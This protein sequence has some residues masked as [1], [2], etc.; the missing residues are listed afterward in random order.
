MSLTYERIINA[1]KHI[2]LNLCNDSRLTNQLKNDKKY[3]KDQNDFSPLI[4]SS[5]KYKFHKKKI[6]SYKP[7]KTKSSKPL[8][9]KF[10]QISY[11][12]CKIKDK[13][14]KLNDKSQLLNILFE[15]DT[16]SE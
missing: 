8:H 4:A 16:K 15:S 13:I 6:K 11:Y 5:I 2:E 9:Y 10:G 14:K 3:A 1:L 7:Y 12:N